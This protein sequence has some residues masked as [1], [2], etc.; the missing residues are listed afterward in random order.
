V[1]GSHASAVQAFPSSVATGA[2]L[3]APVEVSHESVVQALSS[4]VFT[5]V[6]DWQ[7]PP[8][9]VSPVVHAFPSEHEAVLLV[10]VTPVP[11]LHASSVQVLLSL[12][13]GLLPTHTPPPQVSVCVHGSPSLQ[14]ALLL[15]PLPHTALPLQVSPVVHGL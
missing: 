15:V 10:C 13:I 14:A 8:P 4:S 11:E 9:H 6:P 1:I 2:W 5:A 3:T 7:D 12:A